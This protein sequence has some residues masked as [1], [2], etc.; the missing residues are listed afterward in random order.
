M[1]N[2]KI[3][4]QILIATAVLTSFLGNKLVYADTVQG[5]S[6]DEVSTETARVTENNSEKSLTKD[7]ETKKEVT[8]LSDMD[9]STAT[10]GDTDKSKTVQKDAPF[11]TGNEGESTKISL[12]TS[13]NEVKYFDKGIGTVAASPSVISYD[14]DDQGFEKF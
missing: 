5:N 1:E 7:R 12:V 2:K 9:W 4:K 6:N 8:Y 3:A 10:H 11:T 14:I 13:D